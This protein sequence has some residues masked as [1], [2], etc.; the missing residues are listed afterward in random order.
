M[1][2][3]RHAAVSDLISSS[4]L[5]LVREIAAEAATQVDTDSCL[6]LLRAGLIRLGFSRCGLFVIDLENPAIFRGTWGTDWDGRE[7][8]EHHVVD[9]PM[10]GD[11]SWRLLAG[12]RV[13]SDRIVQPS[14]DAPSYSWVVDAGEPNHACVALLADGKL[15]GMIAVDMLPTDRT[16]GAEKIAVLELLA[17]QVA[18]AVSRSQGVVALRTANESL[19]THPGV[20]ATSQHMLIVGRV[21]TNG[22][23]LLNRPDIEN[24]TLE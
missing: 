3:Q 9:S 8:D 12:E 5:E 20:F 18:A 2:L 14:A 11:L 22:E 24:L 1:A 16:I 17:D 6:R 21:C 23:E 19:C 13:A 15:L 7:T 10:P 4:V